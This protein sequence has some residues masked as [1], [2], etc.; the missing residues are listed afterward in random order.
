[1]SQS[2]EINFALDA[3]ETF[4]YTVTTGVD[5]VGGSADYVVRRGGQDGPVALRL[6]EANGI[7]LNSTGMVITFDPGDTARLRGSYW[8][9]LRATTAGGTVQGV[10]SGSLFVAHQ[11]A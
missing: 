7:T 10:F 3:G 1:M 2:A 6:D 8:H 4:A 9:A 11:G 5:M